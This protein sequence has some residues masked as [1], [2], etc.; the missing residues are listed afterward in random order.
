M[1]F[2]VPRRAS[3]AIRVALV[4][5]AAS[6]TLPAV[7][8]AATD[9]QVADS[10]AAAVSQLRGQQDPVTGAIG[11][12]TQGSV[13]CATRSPSPFGGDWALMGLAG[14]GVHAADLRA[15]PGAPSAQDHYAGL[16][17]AE[18]GRWATL[19]T[20]Q[21]S[22]YARTIMAA[23]SAGIQPT[24]VSAQ[25]NLLA[26]LAGFYADGYFAAPSLINQTIFGLI[27]LQQ[28]PLAY[29]QVGQKVTDRVADRI[30]AAQRVDGTWTS[31]PD[32]NGAALAALCEQGRAGTDAVTRGITALLGQRAPATGGFG[33]ANATS[34]A[35]AGLAACGIVRG[36]AR[37]TQE[38][39]E[40]AVD[41]LLTFQIGAG[42]APAAVGGFALTA[43]G[44][45]ANLYA[46][47]DGL[48]A[49]AAPGFS[50]FPPS[51]ANED[52]PYMRPAPVVADGTP[53]PV[54]LAI[55]DGVGAVRL[56]STT[57]PAG[58]TLPEVLA[59]ARTASKPAGCVTDL[60]VE[61][62]RVVRVNGRRTA[63]GGMGWKA[64][65]DG[66]SEVD[67]RTQPIGFGEAV[68]LRLVDP[69]GLD[70]SSWSVGFGEQAQGVLSGAQLVTLTNRGAS[71]ADV[72]TVRT[73]GASRDDFLVSSESCAGETLAPGTSCTVALR[74]APS[75]EGERYAQLRVGLGAGEPPA[76][77]NLTGV[78]GALP[79]GP[80]GDDGTPGEQG[81]RGEDGTAG[82]PGTPGAQGP[83]GSAGQTGAQG[84]AGPTG[85]TGAEGKPGRDAKVTCRL[86]GKGTRRTVSCRVVL[87]GKPA[88]AKTA[89]RLV[90]GGK[91]F[92]RGGASAM[93]PTRTVGRGR[94]TLRVRTGT[95][96]TVIAVTVR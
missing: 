7:A 87:A 63:T 23:R 73:A 69:Q 28:T 18:D 37:W 21:A 83:A 25:Q 76:V 84:P 50:V 35:F 65:V 61:D 40:R 66:G 3:A 91:T 46:T 4:S 80:K 93:R 5:V 59:A 9:Q 29:A 36:D 52:D 94:Y 11:C 71:A 30:V 47:Q 75:A 81:P 26:G 96:V 34:W 45:T 85:R 89:A 24:R 1:Q 6:A 78:G 79:A 72:R 92:A 74:F 32:M 49:L 16:W 19:G 90:R 53:V 10:V 27:A 86:T 58:A 68:A 43:G 57:A 77:V 67:A 64:S 56:C 51:R 48:R 13:D 33:N 41:Q 15:A 31:Y 82:T 42:A 17:G 14:A 60:L 88:K 54:A 2:R 55:D 12:I 70:V 20:M 62:G 38:G 8:G 39:L 22:D 95:T 44:A